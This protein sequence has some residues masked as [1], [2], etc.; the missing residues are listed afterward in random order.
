MEHINPARIPT[1]VNQ[2]ASFKIIRY[3]ELC[4][5]PKAIRTP[6]SRVL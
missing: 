6:I 1:P 2:P 3:T 5:A 4:C